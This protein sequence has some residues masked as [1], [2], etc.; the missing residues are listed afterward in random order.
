MQKSAVALPRDTQLHP[1]HPASVSW[2]IFIALPCWTVNRWFLGVTHTFRRVLVSSRHISAAFCGD[3]MVQ[4]QNGEINRSP[5][6]KP[7]G[8]PPPL[9]QPSTCPSACLPCLSPQHG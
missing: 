3:T 5:R 7:Q 1:H 4:Y 6:N 8:H 2:S 9:V